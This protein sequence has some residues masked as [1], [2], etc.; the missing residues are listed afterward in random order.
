MH[1]Q[2]NSQKF[3]WMY[4]LV[5]IYIFYLI[6]YKIITENICMIPIFNCNFAAELEQRL[7]LP[8]SGVARKGISSL[9]IPLFSILF[10][11]RQLL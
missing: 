7:L 8:V 5:Q 11:A 1:F 6:L 9:R 4:F 2:G 10:L 3:F